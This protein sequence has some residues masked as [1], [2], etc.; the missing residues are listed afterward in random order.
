MEKQTSRLEAFSDGIFGVAITLLA[1]EI[2][3]G[4]YKG[5]TNVNLWQKIIERWPEYFSYFNSFA[6]VLLIWMGHNKVF[7][8]LKAANHWIILTN[9]CVLLMVALFP[10]PTKTVG[11]FI[12]SGAENTAVA[13]YTAF[14]GIITLAMLVLN[15]SILQNKRLLLNAKKS[16]PW[17]HT[18]IRGQI[19]GLVSYGI[20]T[21]IAFYYSRIA[22]V[23]TFLMW[24]FWAITSKDKE[25]DF[26]A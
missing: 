19:I 3:I 6:T 16:V 26:D 14:T 15:I 21:F 13:F 10:Y 24:V 20:A 25:E 12:G 7:K 9:G 22:L 2:G 4:E 17:F 5:A 11:T 8:H 23:L 1:V 18:M